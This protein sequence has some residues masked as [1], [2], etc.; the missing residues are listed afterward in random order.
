MS[1]VGI[2][3]SVANI[4]L[5]GSNGAYTITNSNPLSHNGTSFTNP[6]ITV[7][8]ISNC[9]SDYLYFYDLDLNIPSNFVIIGIEVIHKRGGCNQG[10]WIIDSLH[11]A[12]NG[13][14]IS[15]AKRDSASVTE[16]DTL[17]GT[18]DVWNAILTP[19]IVNSNNFGVFINSTG[20]GICTFSQSDIRL[21]VYYDY[22]LN[23]KNNSTKAIM[24]NLW[25]NKGNLHISNLGNKENT[26][27]RLYD[28]TGKILIDK[29]LV[30]NDNEVISLKPILSEGI[31]IVSVISN[32]F[33]NSQ[34][35]II[36]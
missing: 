31:Y 30:P 13:A 27:V 33:V 34:K 15:T 24:P 28:I 1:M 12:Y 20:T 29:L 32:T 26:S 5:S 9:K 8:C 36:E 22:P 10:S 25:Y 6:P 14:I 7:N 23:S 16:T 11:L 4:T 18:Y 35:I 21:K 3:D 17:G 2:P 19:A